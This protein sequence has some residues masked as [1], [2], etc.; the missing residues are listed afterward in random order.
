MLL[1]VAAAGNP[2]IKKELDKSMVSEFRVLQLSLLLRFSKTTPRAHARVQISTPPAVGSFL[3]DVAHKFRSVQL[4]WWVC[5][6]R[7][8]PWLCLIPVLPNLNCQTPET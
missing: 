5:A 3:Q 6:Q 4:A 8:A 1:H 7:T 2:P